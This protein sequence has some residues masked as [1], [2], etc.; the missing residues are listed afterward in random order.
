MR[1]IKPIFRVPR[2]FAFAIAGA[3]QNAFTAGAMSE[4]NVSRPVTYDERT[5]QIQLKIPGGLLQHSDLRLAASTT[6]GGNMRT[7]IHAIEARACGGQFSEQF[8]VNFMYQG[9]GKVST[10]DA[11]LVGDQDDRQV[12]A[13]EAPN[14]RRSAS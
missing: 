13:V 4:F 5:F 14:G 10:A 12:R 6:V 3:D 9:L 1:L 8:L 11:R 7:I 2:E